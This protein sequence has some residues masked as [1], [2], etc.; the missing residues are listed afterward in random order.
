MSIANGMIAS[1]G[2]KNILVIGV[3]T[4]S[5]MTNLEDR[6]TCVLFGDGAGAEVVQPSDGEKG[7]KALFIKSDGRLANLLMHPGYKPVKDYFYT[8]GEKMLPFIN[9]Q[10]REVFKYAV[11]SMEE[12]FGKVLEISNTPLEA[13]SRIKQISASLKRLANVPVSRAKRF[14]QTLTDMETHLL[15]RFLS[16]W[17]R[18]EKRECFRPVPSAF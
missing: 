13:V 5:R 2:F 10:G 6:N 15:L 18:L 17:M 3:E 1:T 7:I 16:L 8:N 14:L 9:M 12:A 4:L 11:R